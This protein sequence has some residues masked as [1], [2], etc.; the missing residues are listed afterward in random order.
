[1]CDRDRR[2]KRPTL[3]DPPN[4]PTRVIPKLWWVRLAKEPTSSMP[5]L[6]NPNPEGRES[7]MC[8]GSEDKIMVTLFDYWCMVH[9]RERVDERGKGVLLRGIPRERIL[10][11]FLA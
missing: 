10:E 8:L 7:Q 9:S 2:E 5:T 6:T 3:A 1:M 4:P 11:V